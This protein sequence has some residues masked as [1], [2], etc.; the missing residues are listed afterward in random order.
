MGQLAGKTLTLL[1]LAHPNAGLVQHFFV[2]V[3]TQD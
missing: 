2:A 3:D 1:K